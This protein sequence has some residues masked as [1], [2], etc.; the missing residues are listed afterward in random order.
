MVTV[1]LKAVKNDDIEFLY[2]LLKQRDFR[3][4]ISHK[5][6]PNFSK[7]EKFVLSKPYKKW[8][9]IISNKKKIGSIYLTN[10][11]EIGLFLIKEVH[12]RGI[13]SKALDMLMVKHPKKRFLA[14]VSPLNLQSQKFFKKH[15]FKLI[16]YTYELSKK[17]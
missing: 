5:K 9:I 7:H 6:L 3:V 11:D 14:N 16:Q 10:Q 8:Y 2:Q 17:K 1:I 15:G 12:N 13:G 4:N